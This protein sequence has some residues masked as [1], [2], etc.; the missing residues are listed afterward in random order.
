[1][2]RKRKQSEIPA[3]TLEELPRDT[4]GLTS[5]EAEAVKGGWLSR[6]FNTT[7]SPQQ[8][9]QIETSMTPQQEARIKG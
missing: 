6:Y 7:L 1:M 8:Q 3:A 5:E 4:E 2:A 9:G